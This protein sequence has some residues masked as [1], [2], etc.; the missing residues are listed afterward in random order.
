MNSTGQLTKR[1]SVW[2][3]TE[4]MAFPNYY[5]S[6]KYLTNQI[7]VA[8]LNID[9]IENHYTEEM[10]LTYNCMDPGKQLVKTII[11]HPPSLLYHLHKSKCYTASYMHCAQYTFGLA[12][13]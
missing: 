1:Q 6:D 5:Y 10:R 9:K 7:A 12:L 13:L 4:Q 11:Q 2:F 3:K 8:R